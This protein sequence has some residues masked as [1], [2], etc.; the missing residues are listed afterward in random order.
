MFLNYS[1]L[2]NLTNSFLDLLPPMVRTPLLK[3]FLG[4]LGGDTLIDYGVY[5][6]YFKKII[7]G[8][9]V[10]INRGCQ[11]YPSFKFKNTVISIGNNSVIGPNVVFYGAGQKKSG[12]SLGHISDSIIIG[13]DVYIGGNAVIRYGVTI[14]DGVIVGAGSV[15]T[16]DIKKGLKLVGPKNRYLS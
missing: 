14:G 4:K 11:F 3:L 16:K 12:K 7:I 8:K 13:E 5:F 10:E 2:N 6:R 9:N 1:Y 15:V